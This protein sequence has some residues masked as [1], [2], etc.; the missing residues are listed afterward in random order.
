VIPRLHLV[1][2]DEILGR[3]GF[4]SLARGVLAV[5]G[6]D[7]ALHLRGPG[8]VG[9][10]LFDLAEALREPAARAGCTLLVNDR[11]D[12]AMVLRLDGAHLGQRSLP[13]G[14]ARQ[15]LGREALLGLS[16]HGV[17]ETRAGESAVELE[18]GVV[19]PAVGQR[20]LLDYLMVGSVFPTPSHPKRRPGGLERIREVRA[21]SETPILAIGGI[22]PDRVGP[23]LAAGAHGM[24]VR[25]GIWDAEDPTESTRVYLAEVRKG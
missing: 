18:G 16:V 14:V 9:R 4:L 1:T 20:R 15:L 12:I 10:I 21:V 24:A 17:E 6:E 19:R 7:L 8:A 11:L 13:V 3:P 22:T 23:V 5:G 2:D 25:G